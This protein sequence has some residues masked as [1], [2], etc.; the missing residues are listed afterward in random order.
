[1]WWVIGISAGVVVL[2]IAAGWFVVAVLAEAGAMVDD[3]ADDDFTESSPRMAVSAS[4]I[5][6]RL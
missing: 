5:A 4:R 3:D 1:M 2:A 6:A